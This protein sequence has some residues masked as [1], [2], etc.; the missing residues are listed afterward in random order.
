MKFSCLRENLTRAFAIAERFT[1]KNLSLPILGNLLL[2]TVNSSL[3]VS[4]TNL[5]YAVEVVVPGDTV[6]P[7]K[8]CV[9]AKVASLLIQSIGEEKLELEEKQKNLILR[10]PSR[11]TRING[12]LPDDFPIL[13]KIKKNAEATAEGINLYSSLMKVLP[14]SS[15]SEFK[16]EL[17]GVFFKVMTKDL[18]LAATDTFRLAE[19]TVKVSRREGENFSFIL[20][21]R[22]AGELSRIFGEYDEEIKIGVGENQV[23]FSTPNFRVISRTIEGSFPEYSS[24][25]PKNFNT[26]VF[27]DKKEL[28]EVIR[29][30]S[31]FAS[32]LQEVVFNFSGKS[33]EVTSSNPEVGEYKTKIPVTLAG[34]EVKIAF[35]FRYLLDGL[36]ALDEDEI[37]FGVNTSDS[38]SV[39]KNRSQG[40]F[41]YV[42]MPLRFG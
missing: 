6:R 26:S 14:A 5:E 34:T 18:V 36:G 33:L 3:K 20:P 10:T 32:K 29:A 16:P 28:N 37:F 1:G 9:P 30:A 25:V 12:F 4:A 15:T 23:E 38:P 7:G 11:D 42:L 24:I 21:H 2:E 31:I 13:P 19:D 35:N 39:L 27:L 17:T 8:V 41:F 22:A 40:N